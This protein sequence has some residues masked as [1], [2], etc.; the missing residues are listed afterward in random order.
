MKA[1]CNTCGLKKVRNKAEWKGRQ[2]WFRD[3]NGAPWAGRK[4]PQC[5][6]KT[7]AARAKERAPTKTV[8]V[9][10]SKTLGSSRALFAAKMRRC[11]TCGDSTSNYYHC[12]PCYVRMKEN[13]SMA[14][15]EADYYTLHGGC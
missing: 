7:D 13:G 9:S 3:Q 15:A 14:L 1:A 10:D 8:V 12:S 4:C 11:Q 5:K 6:S 2:H